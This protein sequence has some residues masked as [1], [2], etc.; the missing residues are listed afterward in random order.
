MRRL[1]REIAKPPGKARPRWA[2]HP[3]GLVVRHVHGVQ[4]GRAVPKPKSFI[5]QVVCGDPW[6]R[7]LHGPEGLHTKRL[8]RALEAR[9]N[10]IG[11]RK[12]T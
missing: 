7:D 10:K 9:L 2:A 11:P 5:N 1:C 8:F 6:G 3:R 12:V 4:R